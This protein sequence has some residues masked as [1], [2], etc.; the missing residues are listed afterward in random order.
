MNALGNKAAKLGALLG[1]DASASVLLIGSL[2]TGWDSDFQSHFYR[3]VLARSASELEAVVQTDGNYDLIVWARPEF[4]PSIRGSLTRL[5]RA[6]TP[7]G[8]LFALV[9]NRLGVRRLLRDPARILATGTN[10]LTGF[11]RGLHR[12][13][14]ERI[15][16]FLP[17]PDVSHVEEFVR[18]DAGPFALRSNAPATERLLNRVGLLPIVHDGGA[19]IASSESG[20]PEPFLRE[21]RGHLTGS[22]KGLDQLEI[23]RFDLR[24]RGA[25]IALLRG[26]P[27]GERFV[28][29]VTTDTMADRIV[30]RNTEWAERLRC[31]ATLSHE[32]KRAIPES[33]GVFP[34]RGGTAYVET[35]ISGTVAWKLAR[36]RR[37]EPTLYS[38]LYAFITRFNR[39][40]AKSLRFDSALLTQL[41][42]PV[43]PLDVNEGLA[44]PYEALRDLLRKRIHDRERLIV[45]AHGDFGYGNA[46]VDPRTGALRGVIDWDQAREDLA[47]VDLVHFLVQRERGR[48][49]YSLLGALE[50]VAHRVIRDGLHG[51]DGRM[52]Y[53]KE[54]TLA[55]ELRS[56]VLALVALRFAQRDMV[57][58]S[59]LATPPENTRAILEWGTSILR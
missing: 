35:H 42:E 17:L 20:G 10:T 41:L 5:R 30:R 3:L 2:P 16:E 12:A 19:Y 55:P 51:F 7:T 27:S 34:L 8:S 31:A 52:N 44:V 39:D 49:E 25:L 50:D 53:E 11:R 9:D 26:S 18:S 1:H 21:L 4:S 54:L 33:V 37:M 36:S 32:I 45:W 13:G 38:E 15:R 14:F 56:E 29:R 46:I 48:R 47:G 28:C 6:L 57:Y 24:E 59:L 22:G 43:V 23:E 40:T 58:S